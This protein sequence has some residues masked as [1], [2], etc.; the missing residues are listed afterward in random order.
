MINPARDLEIAHMASRIAAGLASGLDPT[1][2]S[3]AR[4][5]GIVAANNRRIAVRAVDITLEILAAAEGKG[6]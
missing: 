1:S 2:T 5:A 4:D 3:S 6:E